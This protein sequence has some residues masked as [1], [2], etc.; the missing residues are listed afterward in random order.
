M[1]T[2]TDYYLLRLPEVLRRRGRSRSAHYLDIEAGLFPHPVPIGRG[3]IAWPDY[4]V[5][6]VNSARVAGKTEE[7]IRALVTALEAARKAAC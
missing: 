5:S 2:P 1:T 6:A 7:E 4:E 3:S